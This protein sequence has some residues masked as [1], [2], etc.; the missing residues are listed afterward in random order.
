MSVYINECVYIYL[1]ILC[2]NICICRCMF[3]YLCSYTMN[4]MTCVGT[5]F[6]ICSLLLP[7]A[8]FLSDMDELKRLCV[9]QNVEVGSV[10]V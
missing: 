1:Y 9:R 3:I 7:S 10:T 8:M 2:I 6:F 4:V 5:T